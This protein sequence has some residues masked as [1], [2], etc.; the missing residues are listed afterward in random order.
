MTN[1]SSTRVLLIEDNPGDARLV[2]EHLAEVSASRQFQVTVAGTL[3]EG[4]RLAAGSS[5]DI[6]LLDLS[7][8]DAFGLETVARWQEAAPTL[9]LIVFT[10]S[11]DESLAVAAVREGAQDYLVKGRIDGTALAQSIRYAIER[12]RIQEDLRL[13]KTSLEQRVEERTADLQQINARLEAEIAERILAEQ[14]VNELLKREQAA[15]QQVESANRSKDE[16][17]AVLS[18]ELRTPLNAILGWA[19]ILR[20]DEPTHAELHEGME[21]IERNARA[22]ARLVEDVLEVSRIICGKVPLKMAHLDLSATIEEALATVR[23]AAAAKGIVL[24]LV[25]STGAIQVHGDAD[26]L[27]QVIWNL[28]TNAIKFTP[29]EGQITVS[30]RTAAAGQAEIEVHDTGIGIK[31]DFLPFVF[32]RFRQSD[33]TA[34]RLHGGLGLGL[35]ISR[36]LVDMHQ[37]QISAAS[38]GEGLGATFTVTL[39]VARSVAAPVA[40]G[41][42]AIDRPAGAQPIRL[43]EPALSGLRVLVVDDE[44]DSRRVLVRLL[45]RANMEVREA[46]SAAAAAALLERWAAQVLISDIAMPGE[47][48]YSLIRRLRSSSNHRLRTLPAAALTAF[49]RPEDKAQAYKA[50]FQMHLEKP[51]VPAVILSAVASLATTAESSANTPVPETNDA[52]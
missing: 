20:A 27:R 10:G 44:P 38:A 50:G 25:P 21:V 4:I 49:V 40:D 28:L 12:K 3:G 23:P 52:A 31:A 42:E 19:E 16:F 35:S 15:R 33:A 18:H 30:S 17:L 14:R 47:D 34:T 13:A 32:D 48:G 11:D 2:R 39:P 24:Q 29:G 22:Q 41:L 43:A 1:R 5:A 26:R 6:V 8:P 45:Q 9:P 7:L 51:F 36:H 46:G 37:G